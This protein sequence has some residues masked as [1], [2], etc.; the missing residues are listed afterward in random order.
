MDFLLW[1]HSKYVVYN[2]LSRSIAAFQDNFRNACGAITP[3]TLPRVHYSL[4]RHTRICEQP[5]LGTY[6]SECTKLCHVPYI[7]VALWTC[8]ILPQLATLQRS[9]CTSTLRHSG[10]MF[11]PVSVLLPIPTA[12]K[13]YCHAYGDYIRRG[14]DW[15]LDLLDWTQLH[16]SWL[17]LT[18]HC[19]THTHTNLLSSGVFPLVVTSRL[20]L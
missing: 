8:N 4:R 16:N 7:C 1:G 14:L 11:V 5:V 6:C 19:N 9:F 17:H 12:L 3:A 2:N 13:T 15:Q 18:V 20:S 10:F